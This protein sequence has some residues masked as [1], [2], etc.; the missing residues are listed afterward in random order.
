MDLRY[1]VAVPHLRALR[2]ARGWSQDTLAWRAKVARGTVQAAEA[3]RPIR[4]SNVAHL[5]RALRVDWRVLV[6]GSDEP[7]SA[8]ETPDGRER[9]AR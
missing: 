7:T 2:N 4:R 8:G 5:A 6:E 3:G 1:G 9:G